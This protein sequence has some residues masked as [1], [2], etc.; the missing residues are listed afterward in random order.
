MLRA[1]PKH[2]LSTLLTTV[3]AAGLVVAPALVTAAPALAAGSGTAQSTLVSTVPSTATPNISDGI[4]YAITKVGDQVVAGGTFTTVVDR[5]SKVSHSQPYVAAFDATTGVVSTGFA[6]VLDG[7]VQ[8]VAPGPIADTVYVGGFFKTVNGVKSKG[9]TLL[10]TQTGKIVAG[11]K[12][13]A[14][15][16]A[17]Q[18]IALVGNEL[19]LGGTFT[20]ANSQ[21]RG[22][23]VSLNP[24]T[25]A[26]DSYLQVQLAGHHNYTGSGAQGAVG[27]HSLA[28]S[29]DGSRLV[30][31]GNFKTADGFARDQ[32]VL[33]DLGSTAATVDQNWATLRYTATCA[34]SSYDSYVNDVQWS[35][36]GSYFVTDA[37]GGSGPNNMNTDGTRS[38]CDA[39]ARWN[40]G[41]TG[42]DVAPA[43]VDFTGNDTLESVAIS[44]TAIYVGGHERWLNNPSGSD[45]AAAGAVPRPGIAAL[46]PS[47]GLP[48]AWNPG[49]N[50]RGKGAYALYLSDDGLYVGSDTDWIGDF[51]YKRQKI[52]FFPLAGGSAPASTSVASLPAN[53]YLGGPEYSNGRP[54]DSDVLEYRPMSQ[55]Q[56]GATTTLPQ[57]GPAWSTVQ[58]AFVVGNTL[59]Y[60][61][62]NQLS[63]A[64]FDG[65]SVGTATAVDPYDGGT[66]QN[67]A[68][69]SGQTYRGVA[70]NYYRELS[71][72]TGAFYQ[73]GKLY[74]TLKNRPD[75]YWRYFTPDSGVVGAQEF[76]VPVSGFDRVAGMFASGDT[77][78][79]ANAQDGSLHAMSFVGGV[80]APATGTVVDRSNDWR[81]HNLFLYG[82]A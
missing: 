8:A 78:Y 13:P 24:T 16:G 15:D 63:A 19:I 56:V 28:A 11:F 17:V 58:G 37:T 1:L 10:D 51:T 68:T 21:P 34:S 57:S 48:L 74:Y 38:L 80:P 9:I 79:Y 27:V 82:S 25:G 20:T 53:V 69:G 42:T 64:S 66:W 75:L 41:D 35:P 36:D 67:V 44:G 3:T 72:V 40:A 23:L 18:S 43:W 76:S 65:S 5:K 4:V 50:P 55:T 61:S 26:L 32:I 30:V 52:A 31:L 77:L 2:A 59:Y 47:N 70:V 12:P 6:P 22:G 73:G 39:A 81:A 71:Q 62:D 7:S 46:D 54:Q 60:G 33:I 49:R 29:P 14:L 45:S